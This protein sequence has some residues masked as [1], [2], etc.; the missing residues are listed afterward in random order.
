MVAKTAAPAVP[1]S[2]RD[3]VRSQAAVGGDGEERVTIWNRTT[4]RRV[5]GMAAPQVRKMAQK[6]GQKLGQ[7]QPFLAV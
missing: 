6:L 2:A 1:S 7:L 3:R 4:Q 5:S